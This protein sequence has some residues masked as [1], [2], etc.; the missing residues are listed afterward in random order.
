MQVRTRKVWGT[1]KE[2]VPKDSKKQNLIEKAVQLFFPGG[3]N[4]EGSL[5]DFDID[6]TDFQQHP[7]VE[8]V[9]VGELYE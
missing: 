9:T 8:G 3:K 6:L 7:L 5:S 4:A 2:S 1:R